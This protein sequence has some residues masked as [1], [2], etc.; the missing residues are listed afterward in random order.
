MMTSSRCRMS[1]RW[2]CSKRDRTRSLMRGSLVVPCRSNA[3]AIRGSLRSSFDQLQTGFEPVDVVA[4]SIDAVQEFLG[5]RA[6]RY[7]ATFFLKILRY[8]LQECVVCAS[9]EAECTPRNI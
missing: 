8:V 9:R 5:F 3:R 7:I 1:T 4:Q 6:V 2:I